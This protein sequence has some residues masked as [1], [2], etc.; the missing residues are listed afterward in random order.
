MHVKHSRVCL[1][2]RHTKHTASD[3]MKLD[4]AIDLCENDIR[5]TERNIAKVEEELLKPEV[6][7]D[8]VVYWRNEKEHLRKKEEQLRKKE[9]DLRDERRQIL[10]VR[11]ASTQTDLHVSPPHA[12][13]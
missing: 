4:R 8:D 9:E 13:I 1:Q 7:R 12:R 11:T 10:A 6:S 5:N 3:L 2:D